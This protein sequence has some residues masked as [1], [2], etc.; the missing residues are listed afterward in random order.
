MK[1][2]VTICYKKRLKIKQN[3]KSNFGGRLGH[4]SSTGSKEM[5]LARKAK[6]AEAKI[7][8]M[9][10]AEPPGKEHI[11]NFKTCII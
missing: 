5:K 2:T 9:A 3:N 10:K 1:T 11:V 4:Q 6:D 7:L 8:N